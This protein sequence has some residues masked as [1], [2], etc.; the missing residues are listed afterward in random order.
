[1]KQR[2]FLGHLKRDKMMNTKTYSKK[3]TKVSKLTRISNLNYIKQ[4]KELFFTILNKV[5]QGNL[6][7]THKFEA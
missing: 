3:D 5:R 2:C 4:F 6:T 7:P 1:M